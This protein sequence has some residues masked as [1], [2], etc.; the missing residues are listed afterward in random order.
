MKSKRYILLF[1]LLNIIF[2]LGGN[3]K[4]LAKTKTLFDMLKENSVPDNVK[5]QYVSSESGIDF[6]K[7]SSDT[8]GKGIYLA[9][10]TKDD[11]YPIYYY[12]GNVA[13]NNILFANF[14]WKI[15]RSTNTGG[16]KIVY[17]GTPSNGQCT[18]INNTAISKSPYN[19]L[20][21]NM[22]YAGY[23]YG[24]LNA[25]S[26]EE[27]YKNTYDS[28]IKKIIDEWYYN[29]MTDY[30]EYLEDTVFCNDRSLIGS[31]EKIY[32]IAER[33]ANGKPTFNC[34]NSNDKF[35]VSKK[36]GN[37]ALK[38][39]IALLTADEI[40]YAGDRLGAKNNSYYLYDKSNNYGAFWTMTPYNYDIE[41]ETLGA[42]AYGS[43]FFGYDLSQIPCNWGVRP[44]IALKNSNL[45]FKGDG[46]SDNPYV[47]VSEY[48]INIANNNSGKIEIDQKSALSGD[49]VNFNIIP[50]EGYKLA[51]IK[52][53]DDNNNLIS[54]SNNS[55]I[56]PSSNITI[57]VQFDKIHSDLS[58][59]NK[60]SQNK[61]ENSTNNYKKVDANANNTVNP[62]TRDNI[63]SYVILL[64]NS[65][66]M[67]L[68]IIFI[69]LKEKTLNFN[70]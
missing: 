24:N 61:Q 60:T 65:I 62:N 70:N 21:D 33:A 13:N 35:S 51:D 12:R 2:I 3:N 44:T 25:T 26:H 55:F 66:I 57:Y 11:L 18:D 39:P 30:T 14:C 67:A 31:N 20:Q 8:N 17:N 49:Q 40:L 1:V 54:Y 28:L 4:A 58:V 15:V 56:M 23:M 53:Y 10:E 43:T 19:A 41:W 7:I 37:G 47:L 64:L 59:N 69:Y 22:A 46:T 45:I 52:I 5:S 29:N 36:N 9:N 48:N 6:T 63:K 27:I 68:T 16:I 38:Y 34:E 42:V 32:K 50:K